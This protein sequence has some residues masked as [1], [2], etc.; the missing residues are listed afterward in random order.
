MDL[1]LCL[2]VKNESEKLAKCLNSFAGVYSEL[3]IVDTGSSDDTIKIAEEFNAS[4]YSFEWV[5]DFSK[6][7]NFALS[8]VSTEW[9]MMVDADDYFK[10]ENLTG[11][12]FELENLPEKCVGVKLPYLYSAIQNSSGVMAYVPRIWKVKNNF[13]PEFQYAGKVHEYLDIPL[14]ARADFIK[15]NYPIFHDKRDSEFKASF[16]RNLRILNESFRENPVDLRTVFYLGHDNHYSGNFEEAVKWYSKFAE[17]PNKNRDEFHKT[18]VGKGL[19]LV[20]LGRSTEAKK[21]FQEAIK[22][23]SNFVEPFIYLGDIAFHEKKYQE[24]VEHYFNGMACKV[25]DT[26]VFVNTRLYD[27]FLPQKIYTALKSL[28]TTQNI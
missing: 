15:L 1:T 5:E 22:I 4:I 18:L 7:R 13:F 19:C 27:N 8:K 12:K 6:A 10:E 25:P 3:V 20:K 23:N 9:V 16:E 14:P 24:A 17:F 21:V 2:I 28:S 11:L 26:H